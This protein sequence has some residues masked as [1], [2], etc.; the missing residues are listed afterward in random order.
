MVASG[1]LL[2]IFQFP[3]FVADVQ[4]VAVAAV[5]FFAALSNRDSMLL[6]VVETVFARL[7]SPLA[8]R[9]NHFQFRR[10]RLIRMLEAHLIVAL[11]GAAV[12]HG[13]RSLLAMRL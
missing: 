4:Q 13:G 7:Q 2:A 5:D 12:R 8:P 9:S 11:A 10:Q 1:G 3:A 6:G